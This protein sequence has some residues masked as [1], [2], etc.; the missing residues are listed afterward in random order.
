[1]NR[2]D[3]DSRGLPFVS[4]DGVWVDAAEAEKRI[5]ELESQK[6]A[7]VEELKE[8]VIS[9]KELLNDLTICNESNPADD[10]LISW[11]VGE[12]EQVI[13]HSEKAQDSIVDECNV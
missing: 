4:P 2:Y 3:I 6:T 8:A 7:L 9:I 10:Q 5:N 11:W 1:M 13:E 12:H